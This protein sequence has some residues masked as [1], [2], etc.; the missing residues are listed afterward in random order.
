MSYTEIYAFGKDGKAFFVGEVRNAWSG[1]MAVWR[2]MEE[3]HLPLYVPSW[4]DGTRWYRPGMS[5]EE[6]I[7]HIGYRPTRCTVHFNPE[8]DPMQDIWDLQNNKAIP[9]HER[10][11]LYTTLDKALVKRENIPAVI[12]AF[13]DFGGDT[14]LPEQASLLEDVL[15]DPDVIAVGWNQTSVCADTWANYGGYDTEKDESIPYNC[16][17]GTDHFWIFDELDETEVKEK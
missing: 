4:V 12:E 8:R 16:L 5:D 9:V 15:K 7:Q 6:M 14:S 2:L 3:R 13:L 1:A 10:I 11:C 17:T